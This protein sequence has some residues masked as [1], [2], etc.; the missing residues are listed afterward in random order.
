MKFDVVKQT[1]NPLFGRKEVRLEM[2]HESSPKKSEVEALISEKFS[3]PVEN[4]KIKS[5]SGN[6]G[7]R[8][9]TIVANIYGSA[10]DKDRIEIKS[11]KERDAE[12]KMIAER[13]KAE[14]EARK[15]AKAP[16]ESTENS[17]GES[18]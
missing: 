12:K 15:A 5:I 14:A 4:I 9:F 2:D 3:S 7:T 8:R 6:F 17:E 1:E 18:A 11:K 16:K 10:Q 13:I